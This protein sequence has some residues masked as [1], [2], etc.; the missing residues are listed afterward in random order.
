MFQICQ[1]LKELA[2][3]TTLEGP[4]CLV[5][6]QRKNAKYDKPS[7]SEILGQEGGLYILYIA[8]LVNS[9]VYHFREVQ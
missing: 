7:L 2:L 1:S 6:M 4:Q 5:K 3:P 9:T 8:Q